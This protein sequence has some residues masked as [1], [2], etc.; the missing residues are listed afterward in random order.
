M[1]ALFDF[2]I[3][4]YRIGFTTEDVSEEIAAWR[5]D[6]L[7]SNTLDSLKTSD[8]HGFLTSTDHS[9]FRY[10]V[11]PEYKANRKQPKPLHYDFLRSHLVQKW[12]AEEVF[13]MEADDALG[14]NQSPDTC[15]VSID[16]DLDQIPGHHFNF[17]K[18]LL[19]DIGPEEALRFFYQQIL[20][21]DRV[22][23]IPG[24]KGIGPARA[25]LILNG[26]RDDGE[27]WAN[28]LNGYRTL[29]YPEDAGAAR[30]HAV[31]NGQLLRIRQGLDEGLWTPPDERT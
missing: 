11:Y 2:D 30:T 1:K 23:N 10:K 13:G 8:L 28:V 4:V 15:I 20:T 24:I 16:K 6:E 12:G 31:R 26:T 5:M 17:V 18:G 21:G 14:I 3:F 22:D 7:V 9:N 19:Y 27:L 29:L 25:S